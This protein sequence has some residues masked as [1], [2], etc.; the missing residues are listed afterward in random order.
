M[1][2][3]MKRLLASLIALTSLGCLPALADLSEADIPS[4]SSPK[5]LPDKFEAWRVEK[6]NDCNVR[7]DDGK[8]AI[9]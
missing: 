3:S 1:T 8:I 4:S 9:T 5:A 2:K 7:I 6:Y